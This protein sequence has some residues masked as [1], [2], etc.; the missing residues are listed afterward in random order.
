M[1]VG[2]TERGRRKRGLTHPIFQPKPTHRPSLCSQVLLLRAENAYLRGQIASG[3][4]GGGGTGLSAAATPRAAT[5]AGRPTGGGERPGSP[6]GVGSGGVAADGE[7]DGGG[8]H[9]PGLPDRT[10]RA[11]ADVSAP[12]ALARALG[13]ARAMAAR[14][15]ADNASLAAEAREREKSGILGVFVG[16]LQWWWGG[17][18]GG[19]ARS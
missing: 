14:F 13:E 7:V 10:A 2:C 3:V 4:A 9:G 6:V 1:L 5:P 19:R 16:W 15:A 8:N 18:G 17:G 12:R 11:T